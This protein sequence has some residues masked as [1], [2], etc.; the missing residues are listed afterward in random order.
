MKQLLQ[1]RAYRGIKG[2]MDRKYTRIKP[3]KIIGNLY[4]VGGYEASTHILETDKGLILIDPGYFETLPIVLENIRAVGLKEKDI[5]YILISHAHYDHM[6]ATKA[7]VEITG[8]K[9]FIGKDDLPLLKGEIFHYPIRPFEPNVL[10]NDGDIVEL[11][12]TRI[13]CVATPG[14]TD[15]TMSFFFDVTENGK[16]Y[17]AGMFGGAGTNT[18]TRVFLEKYNLPY[19]NRQKFIDSI[20]R[21]LQEKVDV[22]IGNHAANNA[23]DKKIERLQTAERNPFIVEGE[24]EAFLRERLQR[25]RCVIENNE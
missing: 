9:T 16:T 21:L 3:T 14:H 22:F 12:N 18:L 25:I 6:D 7:L 11:G 2:K 20:H 15:G 1:R 24:W 13:R 10:L 17:R 19:E 8:A 5:K 23:T 4:F